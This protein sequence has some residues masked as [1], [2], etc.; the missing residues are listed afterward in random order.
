MRQ[1][2][3]TLLNAHEILRFEVLRQRIAT[4]SFGNFGHQYSHHLKANLHDTAPLLGM[5]EEAG[6][7]LGAPD[8]EGRLDAIA[9]M[10]IFLSDWLGRSKYTLP[11][12]M[13]P[14]QTLPTKLTAHQLVVLGVSQI[15]HATLKRHQGIRG[16]DD[17]EKFKAEAAAG[18][19][20][21]LVGLFEL[22]D[23]N[24]HPN[25]LGLAESVFDAIVEKRNFSD[26]SNPGSV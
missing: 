5:F 23:D 19:G 10:L 21:V 1:R 14:N 12:L 25:A 24:G 6:E 8:R 20:A 17:P 7:Y 16:F 9:D 18:V 11:Q 4:W 22:A 26:T 3:A 13:L 15:A 2:P